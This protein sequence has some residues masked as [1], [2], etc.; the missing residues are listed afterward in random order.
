MLEMALTSAKLMLAGKLFKDNRL[1]MTQLAKGAGM[2]AALMLLL[3]LGFPPWVAAIAG[4]A[5]A[6]WAQPI[7]F[8]DLKFA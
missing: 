8:K 5:A 7:L 2:G 6:G 4:G 1:A 3:S